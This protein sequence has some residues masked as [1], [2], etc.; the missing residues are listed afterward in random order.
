QRRGADAPALEP[1]EHVGDL[2]PAPEVAGR[3]R[4]HRLPVGVP[5]QLEEAPHVLEPV[6]ER[7]VMRPRRLRHPELLERD[8][9]PV[10][11]P[12]VLALPGTVGASAPGIA[13]ALTHA[14]AAPRP[15][16][17]PVEAVRDRLGTGLESLVRALL[18]PAT[19]PLFERVIA[20]HRAHDAAHFADA[21]TR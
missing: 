10:R 8:L 4:L 9:R 17:H 7:A 6:G 13:A 11:E 21:T 12:R 1:I 14:R 3:Q 15:P 18:P 16:P 20:L 19:D 2:G 5:L